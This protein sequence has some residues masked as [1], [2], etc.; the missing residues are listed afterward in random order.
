VRLTRSTM[1]TDS[2]S[3]TVVGTLAVR[4]LDEN[5]PDPRPTLRELAETMGGFVAERPFARP[6]PGDERL[7]YAFFEFA[8]TS[9]AV[10]SVAPVC[11]AAGG[12]S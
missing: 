9:F 10:W 1:F 12:V 3:V 8:G 6:K 11:V 7:V 2:P 4:W 5:R